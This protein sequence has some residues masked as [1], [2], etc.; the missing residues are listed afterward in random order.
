P[1]SSLAIASAE[2]ISYLGMAL[3]NISYLQGSLFGRLLDRRLVGILTS[4]C[5]SQFHHMKH[6]RHAMI[7]VPMGS[8]PAAGGTQAVDRAAAL[9]DLVVRADDPPSF[10][11]LSDETGLARST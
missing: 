11:E 4:H 3:R 1:A 2:R 8:S 5:G 6:V 10:T 9:I 7:E